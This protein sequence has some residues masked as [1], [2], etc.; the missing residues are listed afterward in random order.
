MWK[1]YKHNVYLQLCYFFSHNFSPRIKLN[2]TRI[3]FY[4][5]PLLSLTV[6]FIINP[7]YHNRKHKV[8]TEWLAEK[9]ERELFRLKFPLISPG[10]SEYYCSHA[11]IWKKNKIQ[12]FSLLY[13]NYRK[14]IHVLLYIHFTKNTPLWI[15]IIK[16]TCCNAD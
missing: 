13:R 8:E 11:L 3:F 4:S 7:P 9:T 14:G 2:K 10:L 12:D 6:M 1:K 15:R 16:V 5:I